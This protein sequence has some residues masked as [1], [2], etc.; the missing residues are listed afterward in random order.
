[1]ADINGVKVGTP[2]VKVLIVAPD[3]TIIKKFIF[4]HPAF[5]VESKFHRLWEMLSLQE[6][7]SFDINTVAINRIRSLNWV[8]SQQG[9]PL[10]SDDCQIIASPC[11]QEGDFED[12]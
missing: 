9:A 12:I 1:M 8:A 3:G 11:F 5:Y 10:F 4:L 7:L 2:V 6:R